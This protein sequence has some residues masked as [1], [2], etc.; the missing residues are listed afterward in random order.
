M[1]IVFLGM[2]LGFLGLDQGNTAMAIC[3]IG[4]AMLHIWNH[5]FLKGTLF[6]LAGTVQKAT[7]IVAMDK[8]G[9][10]GKNMPITKS[11]FTCHA[12]A[13]CG[14]PP[15]SAFLS[16]AMIYLAAFQCVVS[17]RT[18][19]WGCHA[20]RH[21]RLLTGGCRATFSKAVS[22]VFGDRAVTPSRTPRSQN[23]ACADALSLAS[24]SSSFS[25]RPGSG[26]TFC[27]QFSADGCHRHGTH[28]RLR[29][30][31]A[32]NLAISATSPLTIADRRLGYLRDRRMRQ[33]RLSTSAL[34]AALPS[35]L[36]HAI[37]RHCLHSAPERLL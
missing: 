25:L 1:G 2:G 19:C 13:L 24:P 18:S 31:M 23:H 3:G 36:P 29:P 21:R 12:A 20:R 26:T 8:M 32:P 22:A 27:P 14:L 28:P 9:G 34:D 15:G 5:A 30:A 35:D 16:E 4:G 17:G 6:L 33:R 7:G 11:V 37:H 10:L